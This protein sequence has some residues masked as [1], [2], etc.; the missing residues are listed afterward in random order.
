[1]CALEGEGWIHFIST[2]SLQ[3]GALPTRLAVRD[4]REDFGEQGLDI[5]HLGLGGLAALVTPLKCRKSINHLPK[6]AYGPG[7]R[8]KEYE[9]T[10]SFR[11]DTDEDTE[12]S[13]CQILVASKSD[14]LSPQKVV[15][16]NVPYKPIGKSMYASLAS[17]VSDDEGVG[18]PPQSSQS[19]PD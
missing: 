8:S 16:A 5:F 15:E 10:Q 6:S 1:M 19:L 4:S 3:R 12:A 2:Q 11:A 17:Q 7:E 13:G 18:A 14:A 9:P